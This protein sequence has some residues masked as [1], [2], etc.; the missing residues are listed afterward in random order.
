MKEMW[1]LIKQ[2]ANVLLA[3]AIALGVCFCVL[4]YIVFKQMNVNESTKVEIIPYAGYERHVTIDDG[5]KKY[6]GKAMIIA[7][8]ETTTVIQMGDK[9]YVA[10]TKNVSY[11]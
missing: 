4:A 5:T 9:V 1:K 11:K 7:A 6:E 10:S 2:I 8:D 3:L